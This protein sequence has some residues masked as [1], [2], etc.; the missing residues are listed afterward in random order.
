M[1][2]LLPR[3]CLRT[4]AGFARFE[5]LRLPAGE[6]WLPFG[7]A[8][9]SGP[10]VLRSDGPV[11]LL[12]GEAHLPVGEAR[13]KDGQ[14]RLRIGPVLLSTREPRLSDAP[15][16]APSAEETRCSV[17]QPPRSARQASLRE[18]PASGSR[19][20]AGQFH[21]TRARMGP[22]VA[23]LRMTRGGSACPSPWSRSKDLGGERDRRA[24]RV[25]R[26]MAPKQ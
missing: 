11:R 23:G 6:P 16:D 21:E 20:R 17:E 5:A 14:M 4:R 24:S 25:D 3:Q 10:P 26:K 7:E 18:G 12:V 1:L 8:H 9:E 15:A 13:G 22:T 19:G 2:L